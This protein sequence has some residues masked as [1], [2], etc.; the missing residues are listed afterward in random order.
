M[1]KA[2]LISFLIDALPVAEKEEDQVCGMIVHPY[3]NKTTNL[4]QVAR[5]TTL[6]SQM[7]EANSEYRQAVERASESRSRAL[8]EATNNMIPC[9]SASRANI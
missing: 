6:E 9:R 7:K 2:K 1:E 3:H 5:L 4:G 8:P